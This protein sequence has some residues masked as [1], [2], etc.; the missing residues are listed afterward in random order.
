M[1]LTML[2]WFL[3]CLLATGG[4]LDG[5]VEAVAAHTGIRLLVLS[6]TVI[7]V[8]KVAV[9]IVRAIWEGLTHRVSRSEA[10]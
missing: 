5:I 8:M 4:D 7:A 6:L 10:R 1:P 9:T 3:L 2:T